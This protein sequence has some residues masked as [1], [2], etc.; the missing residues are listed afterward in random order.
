MTVTEAPIGRAA[1]TRVRIL[2]TAL[3]LFAEHG[4]DQ[5]TVSRIAAAVGISEMTFFRHFPSKES[6][7]VDDPYDPLMAEHVA[8][9]PSSLPLLARVAGGIREAWVAVPQ[10]E[11][12]VV[13]TRLRIAAASPTLRAAT[14]QANEASADAIASA[15]VDAGADPVDS[16]IA[17]GAAMAGITETLLA[18]AVSDDGSLGEALE[19]ALRV[20]EGAR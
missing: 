2:E 8:G 3:T 20:I 9:Q 4:Y 11:A 17:A 14:R 5:V 12:G 1:R 6:L 10:P 16:R 15:L 7:V 18:W 19:R 13:R